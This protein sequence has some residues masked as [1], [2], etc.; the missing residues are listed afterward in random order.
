MFGNLDQGGENVYESITEYREH[1]KGP[2][3]LTP[4]V[5]E[6][7]CAH[8]W[9]KNG[10]YTCKGRGRVQRWTCKACRQVRKDFEQVTSAKM[11][12]A[13][14]LLALRLPLDQAEYLVGV[15]SET[16]HEELMSAHGNPERW[17]AIRKRLLELG[18]Q[19]QEIKRLD[20]IATITSLTERCSPSFGS[21]LKADLAALKTRI[22]S[23]IGMEVVIVASR[24]GVRVCRK[25]DFDD[26]I[27]NAKNL[28]I[29]SLEYARLSQLERKVLKELRTPS[30][31]AQ[32]LSKIFD[33]GPTAVDPVTMKR[34][35]PEPTPMTLARSLRLDF[36]VFNGIV[37]GLVR[38]L[39]KLVN[40]GHHETGGAQAA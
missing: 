4:T 34:L 33:Q 17:A 40:P 8:A 26:F 2:S 16:I 1:S 31:Q 15:K 24:Q 39:R 12:Q 30:D 25:K 20:S 5:Q 35:P 10:F 38:K 7:N 32:L 36:D 28:P 18:S 6:E 27:R 9:V 37:I 14:A 11:L 21:A 22:E 23:V 13:F 3:S 19:A 29:R